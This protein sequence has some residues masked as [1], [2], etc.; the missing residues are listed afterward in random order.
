[1]YADDVAI[2]CSDSADLQKALDAATTWAR[3]WRFNFA[4]GLHETAVMCFGPGAAN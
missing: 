2:L 4:V 3:S 1:M